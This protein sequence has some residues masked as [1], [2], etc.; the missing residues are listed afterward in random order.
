MVLLAMSFACAYPPLPELTGDGG[1]MPDV[2]PT[3]FGSFVR[4]CFDSLANV[5]TMPAMLPSDL[6]IEI[7]TDSSPLCDQN[8]DRKGDFCVVAGAGITLAATKSIRAYGTKPLVVLSTTTMTLE[9]TSTVDVS[10][11]RGIGPVAT[12]A[13]ANSAMCTSGAAPEFA[14]GGYGGSFGGKGGN[15]EQLTGATV[16]SGVA[17]PALTSPPT[18][19][20]GGCPGGNGDAS[21]GAGGAGGGAVALIAGTSIQV[22]GTVNASGAGGKGGPATQSGG[23]G[24]GSG[25]MIVLDAPSI[26]ATGSLFANGGGGGQGG[27]GSGSNFGMGDDGGESPAPS[28]PAAGGN[29]TGRDG[30]AGGTGS[31]GT[32]LSG[33]NAGGGAGSGGGRWRWRWRCWVHSRPRGHHEHRAALVRSLDPDGERLRDLESGSYDLTRVWLLYLAGGERHVMPAFPSASLDRVRRNRGGN[34]TSAHEH[35]PRPMRRSRVTLYLATASSQH[36]AHLLKLPRQLLAALC[37]R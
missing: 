20:R 11:N 12:G 8:N 33:T 35:A 9:A 19:L 1:G 3:C 24:G 16:T 17:A 13:G 27:D 32:K 4:V 36:W 21:G 15:G 7:D 10:S 5:P 14:G 31:S 6:T 30:G 28:T 25:G 2:P 37:R 26:T 23:G 18:I 34:T 29:N 22:D